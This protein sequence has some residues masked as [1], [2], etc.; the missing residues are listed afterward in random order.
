MYDRVFQ[1]L[2]I[3]LGVTSVTSLVVHWAVV[4]PALYR[5]GARFPTGLLPWRFLHEMR[6]YIDLCRERGNSLSWC[7]ILMLGIWF[8]LLLGLMLG[9]RWF[10]LIDN[11]VP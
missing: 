7:Y 1:S 11:P 2:L 6:L 5:Q 8:N 3:L 4:C 9:C 10:W